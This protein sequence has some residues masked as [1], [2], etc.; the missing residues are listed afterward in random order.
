M[1]SAERERALAGELIE[2][3]LVDPQFRAEF[4]RDP[5]AACLAAG[6]PDL[7]DELAGSAGSIDL[8]AVRESR[9]SLAGAVMAVA[10]EGMS[11]AETQALIHHG[12]TGAPRG[13]GKLPHGGALRRPLGHVHRAGSPALL[14][15]ELHGLR[16]GSPRPR[17]S[18]DRRPPG[19][20]TRHPP[21]RHR[22]SPRRH[23]PR[24][25]I[26]AATVHAT[27]ASVRAGS[28]PTGGGGSV[29]A[30]RSRRI[31]S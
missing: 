8:L 20:R 2:R 7:A 12:L 27:A 16:G 6:L 30:A 25:H 29:P 18:A 3:L 14:G 1:S 24:R 10:V 4:R 21:P 31:G 28:V 13:I 22:H 19:S 5:A 26:R 23:S 17:R 9:S 15:R 11:V